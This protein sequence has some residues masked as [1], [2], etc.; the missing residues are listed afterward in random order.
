M[1]CSTCLVT[2]TFFS[3]SCRYKAYSSRSF[4]TDKR[5]LACSWVRLNKELFCSFN[6]S[7]VDLIL[8]SKEEVSPSCFNASRYLSLRPDNS[9]FN[10]WIVPRWNVIFSDN[11]F[12]TWEAS[13]IFLLNPVSISA[14]ALAALVTNSSNLWLDAASWAFKA[15]KAAGDCV[16]SMLINSCFNFAIS[17]RSLTTSS[18]SL[19]ILK[20]NFDISISFSYD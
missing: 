17:L 10:C 8:A 9:F 14:P 7:F 18:Q 19:P 12:T 5:A 4:F 1:A 13:K 15:L 6:F 2:S 16:P 3:P 11:P 20:Y